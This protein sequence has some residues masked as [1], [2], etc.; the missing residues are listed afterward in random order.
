[1]AAPHHAQDAI[2]NT[3]SARSESRGQL[4]RPRARARAHA[5]GEVGWSASDR[6]RFID[7]LAP[8]CACGTGMAGEVGGTTRA[9]RFPRA[10]PLYQISERPVAQHEEGG[11]ERRNCANLAKCNADQPPQLRQAVI[12]EP[13][14]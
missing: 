14:C 11:A 6:E 8:F 1:M 13:G 4:A 7:R 9:R 3:D 12:V 10:V 2:T 5:R